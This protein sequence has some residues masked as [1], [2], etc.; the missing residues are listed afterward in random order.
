MGMFDGLVEAFWICVVVLLAIGVG[1]GF[2]I[3]WLV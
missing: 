2:L 3:G 1:I